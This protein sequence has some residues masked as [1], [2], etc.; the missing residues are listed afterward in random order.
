MISPSIMCADLMELRPH[1]RELEALGVDYL[2]VDVMD[3]VF[4]PNYA[5]GADFV[6]QLH[7]ETTIPLDVHLMVD[8]PDEKL[9][10]FRFQPGDLVSIHLEATPHLQRALAQLRAMGASPMVAI[11]PATSINLLEDVLPDLHGVLVMAVNPG[12]AGQAV[13]PQ[14]MDKLTRLRA[15]LNEKGYPGVQIEVDGNVSFANAPMMC[16]AGAD[17]FVCGSSSIYAKGDTIR[18]NLERL[19]EVGLFSEAIRKGR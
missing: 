1:L 8:R 5:L 16:H 3:G 19:R 15:W 9:A 11:N 14:V 17:I 6:H 2:H 18:N 7:A 4:V 10:Y 12:F 13:V